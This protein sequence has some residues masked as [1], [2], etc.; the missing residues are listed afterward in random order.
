MTNDFA[1]LDADMLGDWPDADEASLLG[2]YTGDTTPPRCDLPREEAW[3]FV[4]AVDAEVLPVTRIWDADTE[5]MWD[6]VKYRA[7]TGW[8]IEI[9]IDAGCWDYIDNIVAPDGRALDY[10]CMDRRFKMYHPSQAVQTRVFR[11]SE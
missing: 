4:R 7:P 9:F 3:L 5:P 1:I 2:S 8:V 10:E 11:I 6:N